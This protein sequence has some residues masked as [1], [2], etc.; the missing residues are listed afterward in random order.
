VPSE[1]AVYRL[2][3][4]A[5]AQWGEFACE[6]NLR[7]K[8]AKGTLSGG[9]IASM[10]RVLA[11]AEQDSSVA[12]LLR[13]PYSLNPDPGFVGPDRR[14]LQNIGYNADLKSWQMPFIMAAINT[15]VVRRSHALQGFPY[16]RDFVYDEAMLTGSGFLGRVKAVLGLATLAA[17]TLGKED[18]LYR[19]ALALLMPKPGDGPS[20]QMQEEGF[21]SFVAV[22]KGRGGQQLKLKVSGSRDP[23]YGATSRMLGESAVCLA[24]DGK[25]EDDTAGVLT[26]VTAMGD[27]LYQRLL[28]NAGMRFELLD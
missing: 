6:V 17:L 9:T 27:A 24:L 4:L 2:Q 23:G 21:F 10:N 8:A 25:P 3:Q 22:G 15:R 20:E 28:H 12:R 11:E 26:P 13:S 5:L 1:F 18:S 7:L 19:K 16:G 14:D